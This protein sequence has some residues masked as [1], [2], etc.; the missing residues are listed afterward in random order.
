M[1][2]ILIADLDQDDQDE[3]LAGGNFFPVIP[4]MG[5]F[6][7]SY[8]WLVRTIAGSGFEVEYPGQ[9]GFRVNGEIRKMEIFNATGGRRMIVGINNGD[10]EIFRISGIQVYP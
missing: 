3:M 9:T 5:R 10:P 1:F 6:E 8:G 4:Y 7:A 2:D